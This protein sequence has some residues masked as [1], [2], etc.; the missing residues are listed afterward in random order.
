MDDYHSYLQRKPVVIPSLSQRVFSILH[1]MIRAY[2]HP[3]SMTNI[4]PPQHLEALKK[5]K[6]IFSYLQATFIHIRYAIN[7]IYAEYSTM[8]KVSTPSHSYILSTIV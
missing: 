7:K 6:Y 5:Q 3:L 1:Q 8:I 2:T 4:T